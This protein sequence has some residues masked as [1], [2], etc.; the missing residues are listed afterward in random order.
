MLL[1]KVTETTVKALGSIAVIQSAWLCLPDLGRVTGT[2]T[3]AQDWSQ[4]L[5]K[6]S[7]FGTTVKK[8]ENNPP[9]R[10]TMPFACV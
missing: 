2:H 10:L 4:I 1:Q 9:N 6:I 8:L 3:G 7:H 5:S